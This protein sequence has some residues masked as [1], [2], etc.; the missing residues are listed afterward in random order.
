[1]DQGLASSSIKCVEKAK[2]PAIGHKKSA[3]SKCERQI[4]TLTAS[5]TAKNMTNNGG[6]CHIGL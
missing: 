2:V 6:K 3:I 1:M 4:S 5:R